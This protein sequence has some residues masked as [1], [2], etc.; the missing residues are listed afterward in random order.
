MTLHADHEA[1]LAE[2]SATDAMALVQR[3]LNE[4]GAAWAASLSEAQ[5]ATLVEHLKDS[6]DR[7]WLVNANRSLELAEAIVGIGTARGDARQ[8]AL[9]TMARGDALKLLGRS[10]EA[11]EALE[12]AGLL[13]M[14]AGDEVGWARTRIGLLYLGTQVNRVAEALA[15]AVRARAI[16][17]RA[18]ADDF[19]GRLDWNAAIVSYIVGDHATAEQL[20]LALI[21]SAPTR[22]ALQPFLGQ[23]HSNLGL[24]YCDLLGDL[25]AAR[26]QFERAHTF[27]LERGET[28][29]IALAELNIALVAMAQGRHRRALH[30]LYRARDLYESEQLRLDVTHVNRN[31]VECYLYLNRF[32]EARELAAQVVADY[33]AYGEALYEAHTLVDLAT[34]EAELGN[35][36]ASRTA[37]EAAQPIYAQLGAQTWVATTRLR[38]GRIALRQSDLE[39]AWMETTG[40]VSH[41]ESTGQ[42]VHFATAT[43]LQA[44]I[45]LAR[46][47]ADGAEHL[48]AQALHI[49]QERN[50]PVPRYGAHLVLGRA[51]E[52]RG[53]LIHAARRYRAAL[54]TVDR[55]QR[56][57]TI[58]LRPGF[59]E[60][61]GEAL[62]ALIGLHLRRGDAACTFETLER[63]KSQTLLDYFANRNLVHWPQDARS[64]ALVAE[65]EQLRDEHR[66]WYRLA[67]DEP[68]EGEPRPSGMSPADAVREL[69]VRERRMRAIS[70]QL[71]LAADE[72]DGRSGRI[73]RSGSTCGDVQRSLDE[74]TLLI[75]YYADG[76]DLWVFTL[77]RHTLDVRRLPA[78]VPTVQRLLD[79]LHVN[80]A[81]ALSAGRG[82][83]G[84]R[85]L[86]GLARRI[87]AQLHAALMAPLA[88]RA[89]GYGRLLF[90]PFGPLHYLPFHLLF[91]GA[92]YLVER[93]AV[94]ILPAAAYATRRIP[95]RA[96]GARTLAYS[97]DGRLPH[98]LAEARNVHDLCGG[99][100][101]CEDAASRQALR[102]EP[103][104]ILHIAAHGEH[105][106]DQP[107]LSYI[108]LADGQL[109][110]DDLLQM[111]LGYELVTLT[112]CETGRA[113]I[114]A[115]DELIGL[116]RGFLYAG[117]GALVTSLWQV[118][119]DTLTLSIVEQ[120]YRGLR[121]GL[122][123]AGALADAQRA[124]CAAYPEIHPA[125][126][127]AFQ[128]VG[129]SRALS[130]G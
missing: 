35:L 119:D 60:D 113:H 29:S 73:R 59:M 7:H 11:W 97:A 1:M 47:D 120:L 107:D 40:V 99:E 24:V 32:A 27:A 88:T 25:R 61:K 104:Q 118:A 62:R 4:D 96:P 130:A 76:A 51:A 124:M 93:Q 72:F 114:A 5:A 63:A 126:W 75:E 68:R 102:A 83:A 23:I 43:L 50:V 127:A 19:L 81:A 69:S 66:W 128:L 26:T 121:A 22:P 13:F 98:V 3:L 45:L 41:F 116:G 15:D 91:D 10:A 70:E 110:T 6:A 129:D 9:G 58:T 46:G 122:T 57:L 52:A 106:L 48:G 71:Y 18:G 90:V 77:D 16:F 95:R 17:T 65:F 42:Q 20:Y 36:D 100:L 115:G 108:E 12:R 39:T 49:A 111:D 112:A 80:I 92:E 84:Q 31:V 82:A 67:H 28:Q 109:Y 103:T 53:D 56:G 79:Q 54:A 125:F 117:A 44:Q 21:E 30:L 33:R 8:T 74:D 2:A 101:A 123:K 94:A 64:Q 89:R 38:R 37:L 85:A 87:L 55:V 78:T 86:T 34:A 14:A 105:R